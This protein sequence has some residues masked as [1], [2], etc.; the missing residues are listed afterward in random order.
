VHVCY[1][2]FGDAPPAGVALFEP[3]LDGVVALRRIAT[4]YNERVKGIF[5][6]ALIP[7]VACVIG[8]LYFGLPILG[9]VALT[10]AGTLVSY[11]QSQQAIRLASR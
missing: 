4:D 1:P 9:V 11:L 2:P 7:N 3:S 10:N 5:A 8:A 6:T